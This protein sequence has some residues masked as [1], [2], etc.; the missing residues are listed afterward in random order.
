[1]EGNNANVP[2]GGDS[3]TK[4]TGGNDKATTPGVS[5]NAQVPGG[6]PAA[7]KDETAELKKQLAAQAKELKAFQDAD[8][9]TKE[10]KL[11][12][13][14]KLQ[15]LLAEK[16]KAIDEAAKMNE[17]LK[18]QIT[19]AQKTENL[20]AYLKNQGVDERYLTKKFVA[21]LI[22]GDYFDE[23]LEPTKK[24]WESIKGDFPF[25]EPQKSPNAQFSAVNSSVPTG[26]WGQIID[27]KLKEISGNKKFK[28]EIMG[29]SPFF[30]Q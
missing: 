21:G 15:E 1:M 29:R 9:K 28:A 25:L 22:A 12:E 18:K 16:D 13:D 2:A 7:Q 4:G 6:T 23:N 14:G 27:G 11:K 19:D 3:A 10:A 26:D 20:T 17:S 24:A 5:E 8:K 30:V